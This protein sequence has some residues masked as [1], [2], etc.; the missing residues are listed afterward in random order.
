M[1][2]RPVLRGGGDG[3]V[4]S[5]PDRRKLMRRMQANKSG[6]RLRQICSRRT[7]GKTPALVAG[8]VAGALSCTGIIYFLLWWP[9]A[10]PL[11]P[12]PPALG[13][14]SRLTISAVLGSVTTVGVIVAARNGKD[15]L[16]RQAEQRAEGGEQIRAARVLEQATGLG[17]E[18]CARLIE[19]YLACRPASPASPASPAPRALPEEVRR[20]A[21]G[22]QQLWAV[23][24]LK[25][26]SGVRLEEAMRLVEEHLGMRP[27]WQDLAD[28]PG[29]KVAAIQ[30]YREQHG[31]D[32][33]EA[34]RAVEEY[35]RGRGSRA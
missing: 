4:T 21:E 8:S 32:L 30:A 20:L 2:A 27:W 7:R 35:L 3:N 29:Q 13:P 33:A 34:I 22:G 25:E 10:F 11:L 9:D 24:R 18:E 1:G 15:R 26:L 6:P 31:A 5:L 12:G 28:T 17:L 23:E 19:A 16:L 14:S